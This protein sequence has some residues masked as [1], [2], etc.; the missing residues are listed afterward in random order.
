MRKFLLPAINLVNLV[1]ISVAWG[2]SGKTAIID[3]GRNDLASGN[4]YE[5]IW[6]G[7][8][9]NVLG[10]VG[11]FLFCVACLLTLVAFLPL[12]SRKFITCAGGLMYIGAGVLFLNAP[13]SYDRQIV[14]IDLTSALLAIASLI[15]I[16][17]AFTIL[18]S[19]IE[20]LGKKES[21]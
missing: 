13:W 9:A 4:L 21:K 11:F 20:F 15:I 17:G 3:A 1:L 8:K 10:I 16:A 7:S 2:L 14:E 19:L 6:M 18:M 12:K 5:I